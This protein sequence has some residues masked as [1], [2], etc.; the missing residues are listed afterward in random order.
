MDLLYKKAD[1]I[2]FSYY[3]GGEK[4]CGKGGTCV[5]RKEAL[6]DIGIDDPAEYE[7]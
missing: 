2:K 6:R 4:H 3:K 7:E 1:I 5:E